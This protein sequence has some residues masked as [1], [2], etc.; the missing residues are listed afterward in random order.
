MKEPIKLYTHPAEYAR[1]HGELDLY[2][3]SSKANVACKE[4]IEN[5]IHANYRDNILDTKTVFK[6]VSEEFG[7]DRVKYVLAVT[8]R[9]KDWDGRISREN[10]AW[11]QSVPVI[12]NKDY[13]GT[14]RNCYFVV[15]QAHPCL[16]DMLVTHVRKEQAKIISEPDKKD[17]ILEKLHKPAERIK[18][19]APSKKTPIQE[20]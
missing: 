11:A 14:D 13:W 4:A 3:A 5:S 6:Q 7:A 15:D 18:A 16:T 2:R 19:A 12:E 20:L 8:V 1:E 17:S 9:A 10:K